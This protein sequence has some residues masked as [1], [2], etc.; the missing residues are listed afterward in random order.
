MGPP[1]PSLLGDRAQ[2]LLEP[3]PRAGWAPTSKEEEGPREQEE[4]GGSQEEAQKPC[5]PPKNHQDQ[6]ERQQNHKR[7][8]HG[9]GETGGQQ[10]TNILLLINKH[11]LST[12]CGPAPKRWGKKSTP[13]LL[14]IMMIII[15]L[16]AT[17]TEAQLC[18]TLCCMS[19]SSSNSHTPCEASILLV[20]SLIRSAHVY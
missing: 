17:V 6:A 16:I 18:Q 12:S 10:V 5:H 8:M 3:G 20:H 9:L 1:N 2:P 7:P 4:E 13:L 14:I 15:L 19:I 11:S